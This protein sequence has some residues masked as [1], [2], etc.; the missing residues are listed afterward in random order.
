MAACQPSITFQA[1]L[2][3]NATDQLES[4][5]HNPLD[6]GYAQVFQQLEQH[7]VLCRLS[8]SEI[9]HF[10]QLAAQLSRDIQLPLPP[11]QSNTE[12]APDVLPPSVKEFLSKA[13]GVP[14][15]C[16]DALWDILKD[17]VWNASPGLLLE[18]DLMSFKEHARIQCIYIVS[19]SHLFSSILASLT[20]FPPSGT[21]SNLDCIW[22]GSILKKE[23][24]C[25]IVVYTAGHSVLPA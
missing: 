10:I 18:D 19:F 23:E 8:L 3:L 7:P 2:V 14:L 12:C 16:V 15:S 9:N 17:D 25:A 22:H 13:T 1:P 11:K 21:C 5:L 24:Q 6:M 4:V 20:L